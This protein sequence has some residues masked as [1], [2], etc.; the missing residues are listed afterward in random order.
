MFYLFVYLVDI[1][2]D[3]QI[4]VRD[5]FKLKL[6]LLFLKLR[7]HKGCRKK[8]LKILRFQYLKQNLIFLLSFQQN[9][10]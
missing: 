7:V 6:I 8:M 2:E 5:Y 3:F 9:L 10:N 4:L 1:Y